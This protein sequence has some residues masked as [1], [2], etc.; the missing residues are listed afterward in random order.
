MTVN[1]KK[2]IDLIKGDQKSISIAAA[3]I[4]AKV[5]RDRIMKAY[6][7]IYPGHGFILVK[8]EYKPS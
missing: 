6:D 2:T 7:A 8:S 1:L 3:S 4:L 5:T